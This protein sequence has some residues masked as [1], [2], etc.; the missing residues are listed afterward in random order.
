MVLTQTPHVHFSLSVWCF[1]L[2]SWF[3][4]GLKIIKKKRKFWYIF[5]F[6]LILFLHISKQ[7]YSV[8]LLRKNGQNSLY[9][10]KKILILWKLRSI[11]SKKNLNM[12]VQLILN[13]YL[14]DILIQN[15]LFFVC[16]F[17][18]TRFYINAWIL[19][20]ALKNA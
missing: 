16:D 6:Q 8:N 18:L 3:D 10:K 12:H 13:Q 9:E 4:I 19:T 14:N 1:F 2:V 15:C 5:F 20:V 17:F 11:F 7:L